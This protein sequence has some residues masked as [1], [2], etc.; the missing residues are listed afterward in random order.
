MNKLARYIIWGTGLA[1]V[2]FLLWY[3]SSIVAYILVS[4]V[5]S[6]MG[7]PIVDLVCKVKVRSWSPPKV[8]GAGLAMGVIW[9]GFILFFRIMIPL[10]ISQINELSTVN[11]PNLVASFQQPI[12]DFDAFIKEYLPVSARNFSTQELIIERVT[13]MFHVGIVSQVFSSTA[14]FLGNLVI[15]AFS[16]TFITFFFLRDEGLFFEGVTALFPERLELSI[17]HALISINRLLR[18]YFVGIIIQS[19]CIMTLNTIGL[20]IIGIHFKTALVI[21]LFTGILNLVPYVGPLAGMLLGSLIGLATNLQL[22]FATQMIPLLVFMLIVFSIV[23]LIDNFVFQ[24]L[25]FS[26]SVNAH[27]LEIFIVLLIAGSL[28]GIL[29]MLLAIPG[30]TILRVFAKEFFN[31]L[32]LVQKLTEKL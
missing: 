4:A 2:L 12:S 23:Q 25:I 13:G 3:F 19:L 18:R 14:T 6:L 30:Y 21:G 16:I 11:V 7:K 29:G 9:L 5:L 20:S 15:A 32:R 28:G 26:N 24:P 31:N 1:I 17:K 22:D 10:V 27:P 8:I